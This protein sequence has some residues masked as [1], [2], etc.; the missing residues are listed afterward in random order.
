VPRAL[1]TTVHFIASFCHPASM[2]VA[3]IL[4]CQLMST[5]RFLSPCCHCVSLSPSVLCCSLSLSVL[6]PMP[7]GYAGAFQR[8]AKFPPHVGSPAVQ[9]PVVRPE[10]LFRGS[11]HR[12]GQEGV[13]VCVAPG[14]GKEVGIDS[15]CHNTRQAIPRWTVSIIVQARQ[16]RDGQL[17]S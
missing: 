8:G 17:V 14:Q 2:S 15:W 3:V 12:L 5:C 1:R 4:S 6:P 16:H 9:Q 13:R 7:A 11:A 10:V